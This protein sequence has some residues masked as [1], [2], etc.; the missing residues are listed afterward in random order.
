[1]QRHNARALHANAHAMR[2]GLPR[3]HR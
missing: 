1:M 2:A 3:C